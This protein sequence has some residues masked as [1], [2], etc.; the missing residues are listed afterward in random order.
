MGLVEGSDGLRLR[1]V[2]VCSWSS[3]SAGVGLKGKARET[4]AGNVCF[5][6]GGG[7]LASTAVFALQIETLRVKFGRRFTGNQVPPSSYHALGAEDRADNE[8]QDGDEIERCQHCCLG[9]DSRWKLFEAG[10]VAVRRHGEADQ[11]LLISLWLVLRF[12][13]EFERHCCDGRRSDDG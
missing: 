4:G 2:W 3:S 10:I 1:F 9:R 5:V 12:A 8:A 6:D 13:N 11:P 7:V